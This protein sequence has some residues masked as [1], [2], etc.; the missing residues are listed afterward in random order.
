MAVM[1]AQVDNE[2]AQLHSLVADL[3]IRRPCMALFLNYVGLKRIKY[4]AVHIIRNPSGKCF[5]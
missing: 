2:L 5:R 1:E 3:R 4:F